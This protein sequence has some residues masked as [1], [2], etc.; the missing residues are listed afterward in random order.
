MSRTVFT[1]ILTLLAAA[2]PAQTPQPRLTYEDRSG[3]TGHTLVVDGKSFGPYKSIDWT[4]YS[5]SGSASLFLATKRDKAYIVAQGKESGPLGPGF[6]ADQTYV[7]DDAK[8]AAV[9][10][11][12]Y[13][14]DEEGTSQTQLWVNG[15]SYGP[16][17][18]VYP[19]EFAET[20]GNWIAGIELGEESFDVL[21]NG[22]TQ[23]PF[24]SIDAVWMAPDGKTWGYAARNSEGVLSVVTQDHRYEAVQGGNFDQTNLRTAHWAYS[25][26][27][28]DEEELVVVDGKEYKGYLN[29]SGLSTTNS[30]RHWAFEAEKLTDTGDYPVIVVDGREYVGS[31]LIANSIGTQESFSWTVQDGTKVTIQVLALP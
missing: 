2:L 17:V 21:L 4:L 26:R 11:M 12:A 16:Y 13:A 9:V 18:G 25:V 24:S 5:T 28:G 14:D 8:V 15:R 1:V 10:A 20:G 29:F 23:G 6:E 7:A 19:F 31:G 27:M 22:K 3:T 30:G